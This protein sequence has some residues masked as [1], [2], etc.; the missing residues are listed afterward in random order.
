MY[1]QINALLSRMF[2]LSVSYADR[3]GSR[4]DLSALWI[5]RG[6]EPEEFRGGSHSG[7]HLSELIESEADRVSS[8]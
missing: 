7:D 1:I 4:A 6:D 8:E 3:K 2:I 5:H